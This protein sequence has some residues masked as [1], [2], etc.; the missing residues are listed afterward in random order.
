M[1]QAFDVRQVCTLADT[2]YNYVLPAN[3]RG[4]TLVNL[5][6]QE[7][8]YAWVSGK[9]ASPTD[10]YPAFRLGAYGSQLVGYVDMAAAATLYFGSSLRG[11][12]LKL[13]IDRD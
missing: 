11:A 4:L 7:I 8:R 1:S 13:L 2:E 9:V 12:Q 6:S 3:V 10:S 5:S